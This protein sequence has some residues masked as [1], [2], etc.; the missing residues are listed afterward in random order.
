[1]KNISIAIDGPSGAGKSTLARMTAR[2]FGL[3]YI[4]TGAIY[5]SVGLFVLRSGVASKDETAVSA[6]LPQI[7]IEIRHDETGMQRMFL[8]GEDVSDAIRLPEV[9]IY[10]SNV[11]AMPAVR[12]A[13][14]GMQRGIAEKSSVIMDGRDIGTVVL[15]N[16]DLK[17]FLTASSEERAKRRYAE[18][19]EKNIT[20]DS[21]DV[22]RDI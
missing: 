1:M 2:H 20:A 12:R 15:P 8:N 22:L 16:A 13:L 3:I 9:S 10:A 17:I 4:D 18:L 6:L 11:S 5:R 19:C 21:F 7:D 14:M